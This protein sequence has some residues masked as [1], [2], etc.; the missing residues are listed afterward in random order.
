MLTDLPLFDAARAAHARDP[1]TSFKAAEQAVGLAASDQRI[2]LKFLKEIWPVKASYRA[3]AR[4]TGLDPVAVA[5][6]MIELERG[7]LI[8]RAG[9][10]KMENRRM[11][12][13]WRAA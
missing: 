8:E 11:A 3:I 12:T 2:I 10:G 9:I 6:R 5:R 1:A 4:N 7:K 13:L